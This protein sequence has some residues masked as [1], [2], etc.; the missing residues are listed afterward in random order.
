MLLVDVGPWR[1][2]VLCLVILNYGY[3]SLQM[4]INY[5]RV[6]I[7]CTLFHAMLYILARG[8]NMVGDVRT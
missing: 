1:R 3:D 6:M 8:K 4:A 5:P 2:L 7:L